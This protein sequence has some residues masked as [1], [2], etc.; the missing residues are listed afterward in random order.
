M[1]LIKKQLVMLTN[2]SFE[3]LENARMRNEYLFIVKIYTLLV[4]FKVLLVI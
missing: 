2:S 4:K 3:K 1:L